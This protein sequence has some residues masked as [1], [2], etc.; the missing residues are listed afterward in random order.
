MFCN[1]LCCSNS[2][3]GK[4]MK[5]TRS[6][7][8]ASNSDNRNTHVLTFAKVLDGRKQAIRGPWIRG[9]RYYARLRVE[10]PMSREVKAALYVCPAAAQ[11]DSDGKNFRQEDRWQENQ[12]ENSFFLSISCPVRPPAVPHRSFNLSGDS[13]VATTGR[14][15][16]PKPQFGIVRM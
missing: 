5:R 8:G 7:P 9:S 16:E 1:G 12:K 6:T 13:N 3:K 4:A 14:W 15:S 11:A 10:N 2:T